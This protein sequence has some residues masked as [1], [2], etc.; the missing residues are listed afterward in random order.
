MV[1]VVNAMIAVAEPDAPLL[2]A[3][4]PARVHAETGAK[5][6]GPKDARPIPAPPVAWLLIAGLLWWQRTSGRA[7]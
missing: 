1:E 7:A 3:I 5:K 2:T 6:A 4:D